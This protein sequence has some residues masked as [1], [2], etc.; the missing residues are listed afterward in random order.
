MQRNIPVLRFAINAKLWIALII[1]LMLSG[2]DA[3]AHVRWF[4]DANATVENFVALKS[5]TPKSSYGS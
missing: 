5:V 1:V 2:T 3:M 4:V